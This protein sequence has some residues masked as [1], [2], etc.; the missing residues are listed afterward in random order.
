M[1]MCAR[2]AELRVRVRLCLD[3]GL[4]NAADLSALDAPLVASLTRCYALRP[5]A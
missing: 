1:R 5:V 3:W 4:P 2:A